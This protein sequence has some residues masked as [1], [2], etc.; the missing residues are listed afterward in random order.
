MLCRHN[1]FVQGFGKVKDADE[2]AR[3]ER[4]WSDFVDELEGETGEPCATM[5]AEELQRRLR[6]RFDLETFTRRD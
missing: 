5:P 1:R 3:R 6:Q 4:L 2:I